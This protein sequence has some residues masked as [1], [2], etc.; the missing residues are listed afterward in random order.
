MRFEAGELSLEL[1]DTWQDISDYNYVNEDESITLHVARLLVAETLTASAL[2]GDQKQRMDGFGKVQELQRMT[3]QI[4]LVT[5]EWAELGVSKRQQ[6]DE[7]EDGNHVNVRLLCAILARDPN[8]RAG[9]P[10]N[11]AIVATLTFPSARQAEAE[12]LWT[13]MLSSFRFRRP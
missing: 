11:R 10:G 2:L 8:G 4:D 7:E 1:P 3:Q 13:Q 12:R 6:S 9:I 5:A